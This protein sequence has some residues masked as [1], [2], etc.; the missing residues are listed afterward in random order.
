MDTQDKHFIV[1]IDLGTTNSAVSYVDLRESS[2]DHPEIQIFQVPQLIAA[3]EVA[4]LPVL[5]SFAY[6]PGDYDLAKEDIRVPWP[7]AGDHVV[8]AFARDHGASIPSRLISSAKSWL[9]HAGVDRRA[10]ILPWGA[11]DDVRKVS[12]VEATSLY[13]AHLRSTW[14]AHWQE[15]ESALENQLVVLTVP[16]SF[17]EVARDLTVEGA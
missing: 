9:C 8:G 13:L 2:P 11:G 3:G 7:V 5:P 14:N 12:P 4:R 16:A 10:K 15:D 6:I 1:G 17:D